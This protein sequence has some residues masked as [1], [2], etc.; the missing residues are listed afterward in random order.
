MRR[1]R[2]LAAHPPAACMAAVSVHYEVVDERA[3]VDGSNG[4]MWVVSTNNSSVYV[5]ANTRGKRV[6][7]E[8]LSGYSGVMIHDAWKPY[9]AITTARHQLDLL[10]TNR[11]IET[12]EVRHGIE[13]RSLLGNEKA[14]M[15]RRGRPPDEF[16]AYAD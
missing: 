8:L 2:R 13:P 12:A 4:W 7:I 10:H 16:R 6:P 9:D 11:C 14:K 3:H 5:I 1:Q 15:V